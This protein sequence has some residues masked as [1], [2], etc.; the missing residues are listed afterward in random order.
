MHEWFFVFYGV[1]N[2]DDRS[3]QKQVSAF[4][5][6]FNAGKSGH[7]KMNDTS[8]ISIINLAWTLKEGSN[9]YDPT[10]LVLRRQQLVVKKK[11][12]DQDKERQKWIYQKYHK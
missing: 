3:N 12:F 8:C 9:I 11:K 2:A 1:K 5:S 10:Q 6:G 4:F 7:L